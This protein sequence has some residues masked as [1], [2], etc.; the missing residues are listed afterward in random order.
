MHEQSFFPI[1]GAFG[2]IALVLLAGVVLRAKIGLL[3]KFLVPSAIIAGIIGFA[4]KSTGLIKIDYDTFTLFAIH[5]FTLNFISVGLTGTEDA[6]KPKGTS[7]RKV[8][9]KGMMWMAI[10]GLFIQSLQS[11]V[12]MGVIAAT[13]TF[14]KPLW[15]G[16][17][18]LLSVGYTQGPGQA[19]AISTVWEN[20]YMV[21]NAISVGLTFAAA[22]FL[23]S[24]L[25]GVPLAQWGLKKGLAANKQKELPRDFMVGLYE[26]GKRPSAGEQTTHSANIDALAFQVA[27][28][29][30]VYFITYF[31]TLGIKSVIPAAMQGIAF[32]LMFMWG[33]I[34]AVI[35]R[36]I[37]KKLG[38]AHYLDNNVQRRIT[39]M[40]V[41]F[42]VASTF[43]AIKVS[44]LWTFVIP[45][46]IMCVLGAIVTFYGMLYF[47]RRVEHNSLERTVALFGILTGTIAS[48]LLLLRIVDPDFKTTTVFEVA[49]YSVPQLILLPLTFF[50]Y[51]MPNLGWMIGFL[52]NVGA[53]LVSLILLKVFGVWK[54]RAW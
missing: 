53:I 23:V 31:V 48:G 22:G 32:G 51:T 35:T 42:M 17:G 25:V 7:V 39:G 13:N 15:E 26:E 45:I 36:A 12:G 38:L 43:M 27:A 50:Y 16:L 1:F 28:L 34:I 40:S 5:F 21:E 47:G 9:F 52:I 11:I 33:M 2:W 14:L 41:D 8:I 30:T 20:S 19:V 54:Q 4:L 37:L 44:T 18:Y 10:V 29:M 46:V 3:Q 49:M 24:A 6:M